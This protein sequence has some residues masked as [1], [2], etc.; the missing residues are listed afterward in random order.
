MRVPIGAKLTLAFA[1]VLLLMV[2]PAVSTFK[3][4]R[5]IESAYRDDVLRISEALRNIE[6][7]ER[8]I[9]TQ[10][11]NVS[12][13]LLTKDPAFRTGFEN[14]RRDV[15]ETLATLKELIRPA[16]DQA[17]LREI[18]AIQAEYV[19]YAMS[20]IDIAELATL[21]QI[22]SG[23]LAL[24]EIRTDLLELTG[25]LVRSGMQLVSQTQAQAQASASLARNLASLAYGMTVLVALAAAFW[26]T[27]QITG[28]LRRVVALAARLADG[29]LTVER[30]EV[31]SRD[32][33]GDMAAAFNRM[34]DSWREI[35]HQIRE[36]S[37]RLLGDG[38]R[39]LE[40]ARESS[41]ATSQIAS[42]V[43]EVAQGAAVQVRQVQETREA[44]EQLRAAI[45]RIAANA[46]G[47]ARRA[48]QTSRSLE[49]MAQYVE[50]VAA[51][52]REVAE[53]SGRGTE[54]A[55]AG[56]DAVRRVVDGMAQIRSAVERVAQRM[57]ELRDS[58]RQIG[59]IVGLISDIAD[60][61]NLLA[62]N[63]AIEAARA[64]EHGRGFGVVAD[65]VRQLAERAAQS[66]R[67]ISH[68][69]D[70]I[71]VSIEAANSDMETS[72][73]HVETGMELA[74]RARTALD[75][76][77]AAIRTTDN[78][79]RTIS[80]AAAR[81]AA[82]SPKMLSD[83]AEMVAVIQENK[84]ATEDMTASSEQVRRAMEEVAS[85]SEESA[86]GAEEV[87]A[88]AEEINAAAEELKHSMQRLMT[89]AMD[90]GRLV[91]RF[92]LADRESSPAGTEG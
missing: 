43:N 56:D 37:R 42:A 15:E 10:A 57:D 11:L 63:A 20:L 76:I 25:S 47:Q 49:Q 91:E 48:E 45:Q 9:V 27:R 81:M 50:Q 1:L 84:A 58:S 6:L 12:N 61:T 36:T 33:F 8:H 18:E 65:E 74:T 46:Q 51:S 24:T 52:A 38:E 30:L 31:S 54:R 87:S 77:I 41:D 2:V 70:T 17:L 80:E 71:Q 40:V 4:M 5:T 16:E 75:E 85:I 86:A 60:Q 78:L 73:K 88:S 90:L 39:L 35:L 14:A 69:I 22:E 59:Q 3:G 34:V 68:L 29:D 26:M 64:G 21:S 92:R 28:P 79:A 53:A 82:A 44:M 7:L 72:T 83:V 13:Y 67:D 32:E 19:A 89:V 66:T 55:Q 23:I 62:L